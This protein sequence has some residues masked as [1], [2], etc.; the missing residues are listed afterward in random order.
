MASSW[1][2]REKLLN[3]PSFGDLSAPLQE[4]F[5]ALEEHVGWCLAAALKVGTVVIITN[6]EAGWVEYSAKRF[7]VRGPLAAA[8]FHLAHALTRAHYH[9]QPRLLPLLQTMRVVSARSTYERF[10][11][12]A[13]L[14]WKAAAFAH[15][16]NQ[17]FSGAGSDGAQA[18][19]E[20][21]SF[22]DSNEERTAV[23]IAAGQL[24]ATAKSIKFVDLP[25]PEQLRKQV[26]T[27]TSWLT[28]VCSHT[29][30]L[31]LMLMSNSTS[32][33]APKPVAATSDVADEP[34][35]PPAMRALV[36]AA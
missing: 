30:E 15:E 6:A 25:N 9:H 14:C 3:T 28:W 20:I 34:W 23:K 22:G 27:V 5:G 10:Y 2:D 18:A 13:P 16:A 36:D 19:R 12:G 32:G 17:V 26:E 7:M 1:I 21:I 33:M 4:Q 8:H 11:P 31:D 29:A 24:D 35:R